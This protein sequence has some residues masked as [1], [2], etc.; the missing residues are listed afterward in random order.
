MTL[1]EA[2]AQAFEDSHPSLRLLVLTGLEALGRALDD[3]LLQDAILYHRDAGLRRGY[4][5]QY[6]FTHG[7]ILHLR[8]F[9]GRQRLCT[10]MAASIC[11]VSNS[12]NPMIPE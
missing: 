1:V 11:M 12:G 6:F 4:I 8:C 7:W 5:D 3:D 2:V 10:P 9:H